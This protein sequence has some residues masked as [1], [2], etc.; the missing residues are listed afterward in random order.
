MIKDYATLRPY[1]L[2]Q[3]FLITNIKLNPVPNL[4]G[5]VQLNAGGLK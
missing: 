2:T 1:L 4:L 5:G 3:T